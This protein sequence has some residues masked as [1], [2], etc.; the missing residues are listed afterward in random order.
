MLAG[1]GSWAI[2]RR[3]VALALP[4]HWV[5]TLRLRGEA[6]AGELQLKLVDAGGTN[7]WWWRREPFAPAR[8]AT[9][10]TFR[11]ASL[12]FAWGPQSGGEPERLSAIELAVAAAEGAGSLWID[13]LAIEPREPP[14]GP[15]HAHA[16]TASSAAPGCEA[17]PVPAPVPHGWVAAT[18][19]RSVRRLLAWERAEDGA[20]MLAA[21]VPEAW[22]AP[23]GVG[24]RGL[25]TH[26]GPLD[27][28]LVATGDGGVRVAL[29]G[30]LARPRG[31]IVLMSPLERP[32]AEAT[33]D[34]RAVTLAETDRLQLREGPA[35]VLLRY[36]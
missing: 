9:R 28:A 20:L 11:R 35:E 27:L 1:A 6:P 10:L 16:V 5:V 32:L 15:P 23:R 12:A 30:D 13:A 22:L 8:E 4:A 21:G 7:V 14:A 2:A 18:F 36:G 33:V 31:G 17:A 24:V 29:G 19:L 26:Y 3:E 34:G 25:P